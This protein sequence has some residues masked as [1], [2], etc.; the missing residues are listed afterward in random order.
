MFWVAFKNRHWI[1]TSNNDVK[2][3][4]LHARGIRSPLNGPSLRLVKR[5]VDLSLIYLRLS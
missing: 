4:C 5:K 2:R 3:R 1:V